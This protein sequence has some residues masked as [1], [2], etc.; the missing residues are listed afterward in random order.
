V[1]DVRGKNG[2][3]I[4]QKSPHK[5]VCDSFQNEEVH[6]LIILPR[7]FAKTLIATM[8][9]VWYCLK[10]P[11]RNILLVTDVVHK[12]HSILKSAKKMIKSNIYIKKLF[13]NNLLSENGNDSSRLTLSIRK[14]SKKEPNVL[15]YSMLQTP[16]SLRADVVIFEDV[17]SHNYQTSSRIKTRTDKNFEAVLPILEKDAKI[18]YIGTRFH[19]D[20]IPSQIRKSNAMTNKWDIIEESAEDSDGKALFPDIIDDDELRRLK[21]SMSA[22]FYASQYLNKPISPEQTLFHLEDYCFY[23]EIPDSKEF[24]TILAGVDLAISTNENADNRAIVFIGITKDN[25]IYLLDAYSSKEKVDDFY[26]S[27]KNYCM[28]WKPDRVFVESNGAFKLV[29]DTFV[30]RSTKD[31]SYIPFADIVNSKNKELRIELTLLTLLKN[32]VLLLPCEVIYRNNTSL[33]NLIDTEMTFF[34]PSIHTNKDDLLDALELVCSN[35]KDI[36]STSIC[37]V[38]GELR[39]S[40]L[41]EIFVE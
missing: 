19:Y 40:I 5:R 25:L 11:D 29:Y 7:R 4:I 33:S 13:G 16:Q 31:G 37:L 14:S 20:D 41:D 22:S 36:S 18:V 10:Y 38:G 17:I 30:D 32:K 28:K 34:N 21:S 12:A 27:M 2:K 9:I 1:I 35:A 15:A 8:F 39:T 6:S 26:Q 3:P 24:K 23:T